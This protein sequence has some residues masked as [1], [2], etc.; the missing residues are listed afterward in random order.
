MKKEPQRQES[1]WEHQST[2]V[3]NFLKGTCT[4]LLC[5]CWHPEC[6]FYKSDPGCKFG[7]ECLFPAL[8][9]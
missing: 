2:A 5:D 4:K 8:E 6:K 3:Q 9:G 7:T 1:V